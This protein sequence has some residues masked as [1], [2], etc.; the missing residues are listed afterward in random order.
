VQK[1]TDVVSATASYERWMASHT[2]VVQ[3]DLALKHE[4]MAA[5]PFVFLR[6]TFYRWIELFPTVCTDLMD[7]PYVTAVGDLHIENF[8]TW[9][10]REGRL[11][12]GVNDL[13][14]A[15]SLPYVSDL[16]RLATSVTLGIDRGDLRL[17]FGQACEAICEGYFSSLDRG[18]EPIVLSERHR[19]LREVALGEARDPKKFWAKMEEL[20]RLTRVPPDVVRVLEHAL[21]DRNVPYS[22]RTRVAGVGSLGRPRFVA[23]ATYEGG[24]LAR[25]AKAWLPS[26]AEPGARR[27]GKAAIALLRDGTRSPDPAWSIRGSWIV[28]RLAPDCSRIEIDDLP[29]RRDEWKLLRAMGWETANIHLATPNIGKRVSQDLR[30][31]RRRWLERAT[32]AMADAT[33]SDWKAWVRDGPASSA[34]R[35]RSAENP[36]PRHTPR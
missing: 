33:I 20:P 16:V 2:A 13:D 27:R 6:A 5:S 12:W 36:S 15:S 26:A 23:L 31:R 22:V 18:G 32:A 34:F 3:K 9:R 29:K 35:R 28:R 14:E 19:A 21:P 30:G 1:V 4:R 8:G 17:R 25:E 24:W 10:D 11:V 7:A